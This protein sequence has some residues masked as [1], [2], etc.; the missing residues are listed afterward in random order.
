M[1]P[2]M[3]AFVRWGT[4]LWVWHK[5]F[6]IIVVFIM[7]QIVI[8]HSEK[9][10]VRLSSNKES[11][12]CVVHLIEAAS[13]KDQKAHWRTHFRFHRQRAH[14]NCDF[15]FNF[16]SLKLTFAIQCHIWLIDS[17]A[18]NTN[19]KISFVFDNICH[20][21]GC[22]IKGVGWWDSGSRYKPLQLLCLIFV[23][24]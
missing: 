19:L 14:S 7:L 17:P 23:F 3:H 15:H 5:R 1:L 24:M 11:M 22:A 18:L 16:H 10:C 8:T 9:R 20:N 6:L 21:F 4:G 13:E 12:Y 2:S